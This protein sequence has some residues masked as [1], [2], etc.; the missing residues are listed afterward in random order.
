MYQIRFFQNFQRWFLLLL[1]TKNVSLSYVSLVF[2]LSLILAGVIFG[3]AL[4]HRTTN[5]WA[6]KNLGDS[7]LTK[8]IG[9]R[10]IVIGAFHRPKEESN[11]K[12]DFAVSFYS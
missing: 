10:P 1:K 5:M 6:L 4:Y 9:R 8:E 11:L 2:R 7:L 3:F 12:E